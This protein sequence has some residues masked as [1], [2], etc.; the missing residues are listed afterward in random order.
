MIRLPIRF[1]IQLP[2]GF[3][4]KFRMRFS[5]V[6]WFLKPFP[7]P[8]RVPGFST[9]FPWVADRIPDTIRGS[10]QGSRG[11]DSIPNSMFPFRFRIRFPTRAPKRALKAPDTTSLSK[12]ARNK[13]P[14][15]Y[16]IGFLIRFM[17]EFPIG[18]QG[19]NC[20]LEVPYFGASLRSGIFFRLI[21]CRK[22]CNQWKRMHR[23]GLGVISPDI[24]FVARPTS[25]FQSHSVATSMMI[26]QVN[27]CYASSLKNEKL[28]KRSNLRMTSLCTDFLCN[29]P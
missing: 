6:S 7:T 2:I 22:F 3:Q 1:L 9:G 10:Q 28:V 29:T 27:Q 26:R 4:F 12:K 13:A 25:M 16:P 18:L 15:Y 21:P 11:S 24:I 19:P 17:I 14:Q 23:T 8:N 5:K 20:F